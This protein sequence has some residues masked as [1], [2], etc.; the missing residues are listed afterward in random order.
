MTIP[1][2]GASSGPP[3]GPVLLVGPLVSAEV[4]PSVPGALRI[5]LEVI[6]DMPVTAQ[7]VQLEEAP[8]G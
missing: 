5:S 2:A 4:P 7:P 1:G 6:E 3:V 8:A